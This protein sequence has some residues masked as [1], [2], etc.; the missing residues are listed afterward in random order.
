MF[1]IKATP[2]T[3]PSIV[4][5]CDFCKPSPYLETR[6]SIDRIKPSFIKGTIELF[7]AIL[8]EYSAG[9]A[10]KAAIARLLCS[11]VWF[12]LKSALSPA[13]AF[14]VST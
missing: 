8:A 4:I 2:I 1:A 7:A 6:S 13:H 11:E 12:T 3:F 10:D 9:S 5:N 14:A